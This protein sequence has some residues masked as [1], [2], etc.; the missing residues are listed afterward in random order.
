MSQ[1]GLAAEA[2]DF[3]YHPGKN[4]FYTYFYLW[5]ALDAL[6]VLSRL[7]EQPT[8]E[9]V[10]L[11]RLAEGL[12]KFCKWAAWTHPCD[13]TNDLPER[14]PV[15]T[16][17][18]AVADAWRDCPLV[19]SSPVSSPRPSAEKLGHVMFVVFPLPFRRQTSPS[20]ILIKRAAG[21]S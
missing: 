12:L 16:S 8:L 2:R 14:T 13:Y 5:L 1:G 15:N 18:S 11:Y 4:I 19:H 3:Y 10:N 17:K 6:T 20:A 7:A 9:T 21:V